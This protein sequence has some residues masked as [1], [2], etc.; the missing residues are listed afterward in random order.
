MKSSLIA[1]RGGGVGG[2]DGTALMDHYMHAGGRVSNL[3]CYLERC[4]HPAYCA[5][6]NMF[7]ALS[8]RRFQY[9]D[10]NMV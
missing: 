10:L 7:F 1:S 3:V 2:V 6:S 5:C 8:S 9:P 4:L